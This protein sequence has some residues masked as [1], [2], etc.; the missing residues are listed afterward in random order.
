MELFVI[1]L[2]RA[3]LRDR[4]PARW[5]VKDL[6][7][8]LFSALDCGLTRRDQVVG[9]QRGIEV[10]LHP[11]DLL[12][13]VILDHVFFAE[14]ETQRQQAERRRHGQG[15]SEPETAPVNFFRHG[16]ER[17]VHDCV[18]WHSWPLWTDQPSP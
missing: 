4:V 17:G 13:R 3:Q 1:D 16:V 15:E 6:G 2:H 12:T 10:A 14:G 11:E 18:S 5:L 7:G 8:L 9:K